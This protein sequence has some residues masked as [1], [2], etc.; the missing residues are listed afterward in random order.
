MM[1]MLQ[2]RHEKTCGHQIKIVTPPLRAD[3]AQLC[4]GEGEKQRSNDQT[5]NDQTNY[6]HLR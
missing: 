6:L 4:P 5:K 2:H 1:S 3:K